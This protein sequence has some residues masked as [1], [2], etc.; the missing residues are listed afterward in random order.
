MAEPLKRPETEPRARPVPA[1]RERP[2]SASVRLEAICIAV[3]RLHDLLA[4]GLDQ[5][6]F[7]RKGAVCVSDPGPT[8][9]R[10]N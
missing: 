7:H 10:V 5:T 4:G 2:E 1:P 3:R 8:V 9:M 6:F